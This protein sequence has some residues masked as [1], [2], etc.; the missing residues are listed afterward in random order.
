MEIDKVLFEADKPI[1][2]I[3]VEG[4]Y[5]SIPGPDGESYVLISIDDHYYILLLPNRDI[6]RLRKEINR[7]GTGFK[8]YNEIKAY[9][10]YSK[11]LIYPTG[12]Q[13][14][15]IRPNLREVAEDHILN[16]D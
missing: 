9:N 4:E 10:S 2:K 5:T 1:R 13:D 12:D 8:V 16:R 14:S 7:G 11:R 6:D 15:N 3:N